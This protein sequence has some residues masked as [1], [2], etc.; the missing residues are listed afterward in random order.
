MAFPLCRRQSP[1][2]ISRFFLPLCVVTPPP[3]SLPPKYTH[4]Y[5]RPTTRSHSLTVGR[6]QIAL[7]FDN[8]STIAFSV[9]MAV[10]S[11]V[12]LDLWKRRCAEIQCVQHTAINLALVEVADEAN[13]SLRILSMPV[14][15]VVDCLMLQRLALPVGLTSG[16]CRSMLVVR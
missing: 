15:S 7:I 10:W 3:P 2:T 6:E 13:F 1:S 12:F 11:S 9:F 4:I 5:T 14:I 8:A 16:Y